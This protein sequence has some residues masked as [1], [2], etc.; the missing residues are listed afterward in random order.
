MAH[1]CHP[2]TNGPP[3]PQYAG[4]WCAA[5]NTPWVVL[6]RVVVR[7]TAIVTVGAFGFT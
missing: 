2:P 7:I 4:G 5:D 6:L 3:S 1:L